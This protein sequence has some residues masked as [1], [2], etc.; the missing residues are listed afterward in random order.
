MATAVVLD[1]IGGHHQEVV[2]AVVGEPLP[3]YG[4]GEVLQEDVALSQVSGDEERVHPCLT[5]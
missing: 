1:R 3:H 2:A 4:R 5:E